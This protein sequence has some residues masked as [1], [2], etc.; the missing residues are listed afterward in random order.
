M[1]DS[2]LRIIYK[3]GKEETIYIIEAR[4]VGSIGVDK[5]GEVR[6]LPSLL[7]HPTGINIRLLNKNN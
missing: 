2:D 4:P 6:I 5:E 1:K 7:K 3:N